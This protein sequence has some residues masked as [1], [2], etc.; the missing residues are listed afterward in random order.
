MR[1]VVK[2]RASILARRRHA[3]DAQCSEF[4]PQLVGELVFNIYFVSKRNDLLVC[5]FFRHLPKLCQ[6]LTK[7]CYLIKIHAEPFFSNVR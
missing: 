4:F 7:V 2:F 1:S 6:I 3:K 5:K